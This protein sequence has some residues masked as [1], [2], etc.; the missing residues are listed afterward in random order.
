MSFFG[1]YIADDLIWYALFSV[2][3]S[4]YNYAQ[5]LTNLKYIRQYDYGYLLESGPL[6]RERSEDDLIPI[7]LK[8]VYQGVNRVALYG[9]VTL[10]LH[11]FFKSFIH[12]CR[13]CIDVGGIFYRMINEHGVLLENNLLP[14]IY[15]IRKDFI[16]LYLDK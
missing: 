6:K 12:I 5:N 14:F 2:P 3:Y 4:L 8:V 1:I 7:E 13:S 11:D 15:L 9:K 16:S 10:T